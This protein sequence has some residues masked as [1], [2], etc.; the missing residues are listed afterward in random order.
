MLASRGKYSW[1]KFIIT[2]IERIKVSIVV[3]NAWNRLEK[4]SDGQGHGKYWQLKNKLKKVVN[5]QDVIEE[6]AIARKF[7]IWENKYIRN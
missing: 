1:G 4:S 3:K 6:E 7:N 2:T 5:N